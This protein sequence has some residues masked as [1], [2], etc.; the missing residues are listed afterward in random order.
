MQLKQP[1]A[2]HTLL[3]SESEATDNKLKHR[4]WD[5]KIYYFHLFTKSPNTDDVL[6]FF[7]FLRRSKVCPC[8]KGATTDEYFGWKIA[9]REVRWIKRTINQATNEME[10]WGINSICVTTKKKGEITEYI[11][12]KEK[13]LIGIIIKVKRVGSICC[14]LTCF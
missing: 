7:Y 10:K 12:E 9:R 6:T 14:S 11:K 13:M 8:G 2:P 1:Q 3:T 4:K 5:L